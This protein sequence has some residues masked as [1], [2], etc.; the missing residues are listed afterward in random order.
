M[1]VL[2]CVKQ[3]GGCQSKVVAARPISG[4]KRKWRKD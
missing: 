4:R 2:M 3:G 1:L